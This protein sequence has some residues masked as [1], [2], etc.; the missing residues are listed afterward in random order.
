MKQ[1]A[2]EDQIAQTNQ[3]IDQLSA[4]MA[5]INENLV[6]AAADMKKELR[7]RQSAVETMKLQ[8]ARRL[9]ELEARLIDVISLSEQ[10]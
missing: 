3:I 8:T 6:N 9:I 5:V 2:I 10:K 7:D 1:E 4:E